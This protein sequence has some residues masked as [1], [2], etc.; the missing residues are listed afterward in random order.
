MTKDLEALYQLPAQA[1]R[2][3]AAS[4]R[5]GPLSLG[6]NAHEVHHLV[7]PESASVFAC[8]ETLSRGGMAPRH[9]SVMLDAL[10]LS[11]D[12]SPDP[13]VLF[14]LVLSGPEV[15][16][17]P[18]QDTAAA[19]Q[20]LVQEAEEEVLLVGYVIYDGAL[21]FKPLADKFRDA[22]GLKVIFCF[23]IP[24][25][26]GDAS[27]YN[28]IVHR[29]AREFR[30]KHWPWPHLPELYYDPRALA[31]TGEIRAS[32]HAK[33]AVVD[34]KA[35]LITSANFT[36]AAHK[37]NIELGLLVRH[38]PIAER[39]AGYFRGLRENK[40]LVRCPLE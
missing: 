5:E 16:G 19:F 10:A 36:E 18:T 27:P 22:P 6:L 33:C 39:I 38:A 13:A 24:R 20:M 26:P 21:I 9:L 30:E 32:L 37:R 8:L 11:L 28:E 1:L 40:V 7:G 4:L 2:A 29:F 34:R 25:R 14:E 23:D 17:V 12:R 35:A 15:S 31:S 3:L